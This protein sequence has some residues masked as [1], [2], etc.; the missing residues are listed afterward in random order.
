LVFVQ[1]VK[2]LALCMSVTQ[3]H[4]V[5]QVWGSVL[6]LL[7]ENSSG[8]FDPGDIDCAPSDSKK[9]GFLC[10]SGWMC[11]P[12]LKKV[13]QGVIGQKQFSHVW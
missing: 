11:G 5:D 8:T 4:W 3:E 7:I 6:E 9:N 13:D 10:Y 2:D 12:S 1:L